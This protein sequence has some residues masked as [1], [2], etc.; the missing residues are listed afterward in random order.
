LGVVLP[1]FG[2]GRG[3]T[4][5]PLVE[6]NDAI[7]IR[8]KVAPTGAIGSATRASMNEEHGYTLGV[9][10]FFQVKFMEIGNL[11]TP[12]LGRLYFRIE[13]LHAMSSAAD[14]CA[15]HRDILGQNGGDG[16]I[17]ETR[18]P[19][20]VGMRLPRPLAFISRGGDGRPACARS[21]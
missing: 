5:S 20:R 4:C 9:A 2:M 14:G 15:T 7:G 16:D 13:N 12:G 19:H 17:A 3:A 21:R 8:I 10:G 1:Q 18:E 11:E 6:H